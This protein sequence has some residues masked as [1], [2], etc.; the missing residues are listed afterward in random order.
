MFHDNLLFKP[1]YV[2]PA[3]QG[4]TIII[5]RGIQMQEIQ[6]E[7]V[8]EFRVILV[9]DMP[10]IWNDHITRQRVA[11]YPFWHDLLEIAQVVMITMRQHE[12]ALDAVI[13]LS[14]GGRTI[15]HSRYD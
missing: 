14:D 12:W 13:G 1:V 9:G 15:G 7:L 10:G 11:P 3:C 4:C 6:Q 5:Q 8:E 2:N